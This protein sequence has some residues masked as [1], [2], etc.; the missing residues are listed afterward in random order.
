[1]TQ[2]LSIV[3]GS[4]PLRQEQ[5]DTICIPVTVFATVWCGPPTNLLWKWEG[6]W[7]YWTGVD[8]GDRGHRSLSKSVCLLRCSVSK[9]DFSL[10]V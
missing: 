1:M 9:T 4:S 7:D 5:V 3:P 10:S 6:R 2:A 8:L